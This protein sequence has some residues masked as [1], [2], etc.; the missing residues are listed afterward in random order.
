ME[1]MKRNNFTPIEALVIVLGATFA[2]YFEGPLMLIVVLVAVWV[3]LTLCDKLE[4][5]RQTNSAH[6]RAVPASRK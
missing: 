6:K 5:R 3:A 1:T 2:I 4:R